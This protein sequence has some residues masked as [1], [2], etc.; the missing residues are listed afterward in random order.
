M[1]NGIA[2]P[3]AVIRGAGYDNIG[4]QALDQDIGLRRISLLAGGKRKADWEAKNTH[5]HMDFSA[6]AAS[7]LSGEQIDASCV[8]SKADSLESC[9]IANENLN[10]FLSLTSYHEAPS[11]SPGPLL[12][13]NA[14]PYDEE[15]ANP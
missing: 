3:I 11:L 8:H 14:W 4:G 6:Q 15:V 1:G 7:E 9:C 13:S 2:P 12:R 10:K 5:G